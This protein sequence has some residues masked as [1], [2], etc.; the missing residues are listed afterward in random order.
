MLE[1][2]KEKRMK[3]KF[4]KEFGTTIDDFFNEDEKKQN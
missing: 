4:K 1:L 3:D 2:I